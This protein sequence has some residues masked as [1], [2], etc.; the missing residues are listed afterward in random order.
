MIK[1]YRE[2][3]DSPELLA[4]G[5]LRVAD[6]LLGSKSP[7]IFTGAGL[8][9]G[10][11]VPDYRSGSETQIRTGPGVWSTP[12]E[13]RP[14]IYNGDRPGVVRAH[15]ALPNESHIMIRELLEKG[16]AFKVGPFGGG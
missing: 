3:L 12:S 7:I 9:T 4:A 5:V 6:L 11:G 14:G 16:L 10:S 1:L 13:L 15:A 8:S 2:V